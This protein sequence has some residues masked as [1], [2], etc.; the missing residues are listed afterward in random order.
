[1]ATQVGRDDEPEVVDAVARLPQIG[2]NEQSLSGILCVRHNM[3]ERSMY[4]EQQEA[5]VGASG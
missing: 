2:C 1:M 5:E 3:Y 4:A